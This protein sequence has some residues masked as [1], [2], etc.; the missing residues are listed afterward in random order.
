MYNINY[1]LSHDQNS[2]FFVDLFSQI[3]SY[4]FIWLATVYLTSRVTTFFIG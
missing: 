3:N 2:E 4:I 1:V